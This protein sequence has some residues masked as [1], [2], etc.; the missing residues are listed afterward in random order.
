MA[1]Q[2][3][4]VLEVMQEKTDNQGHKVHLVLQA[5]MEKGAPQVLLDLEDF[6]YE[7]TCIICYGT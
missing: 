1:N 5:L 3:L 7:V 4:T 6:K 2:V